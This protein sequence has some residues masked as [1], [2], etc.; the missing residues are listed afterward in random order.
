MDA[1]LGRETTMLDKLSEIIPFMLAAGA[2]QPHFSF[3]RIIEAI[4]IGAVT[5]GIAVYS[6][7]QVITAKLDMLQTQISEVKAEVKVIRGDIYRPRG[8]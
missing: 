3:Q 6:T 5:A 7:Q 1:N 2:P 8:S 4:I